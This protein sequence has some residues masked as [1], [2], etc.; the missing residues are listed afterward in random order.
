MKA[1]KKV[2]ILGDMYE[3]GDES[4]EEHRKLGKLVE[5]ENFDEVY[6]CGK[7]IKVALE[8]CPNAAYFEE[9]QS[10]AKTLKQ[11]QYEHT[12]IL[13]KASRGIGLETILNDL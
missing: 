7:L 11:K 4:D 10:L 12:L 3:L 5:A 6:F 8:F 9:K 1:V 2:A 13:L